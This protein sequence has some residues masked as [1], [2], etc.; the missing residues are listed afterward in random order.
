[1]GRPDANGNNPAQN[2]VRLALVE[3]LEQCVEAVERLARHFS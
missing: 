1:L 2:H 3:P